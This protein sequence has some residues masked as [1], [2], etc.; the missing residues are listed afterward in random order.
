MMKT[1]IA[2]FAAALLMAGCG[3]QEREGSYVSVPSITLYPYNVAQMRLTFGA[4]ATL[5]HDQGDFAYHRADEAYT[6]TYTLTQQDQLMDGQTRSVVTAIEYQTKEGYA[7]SADLSAYNGTLNVGETLLISGDLLL[8]GVV[9][10]IE[11]ERL[12]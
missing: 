4:G 12:E 1:G 8:G 3:T 11:I 2:F 10:K 6:G 7:L 9:S 5:A